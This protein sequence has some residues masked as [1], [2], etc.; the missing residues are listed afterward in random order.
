MKQ[1]N[2]NYT[3]NGEVYT[4][5]SRNA[6]LN[7]YYLESEA[8]NRILIVITKNAF[9]FYRYSLQSSTTPITQ[10]IKKFDK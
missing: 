2:E 1:T 9:V 5:R 6:V 3:I 4:L 8:G 7:Q 10:N